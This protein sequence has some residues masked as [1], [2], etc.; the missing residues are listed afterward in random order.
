MIRRMYRAGSARW[1]LPFSYSNALTQPHGSVAFW[2][3][4][5][6]CDLGIKPL[7]W[8]QT[9]AGRLDGLVKPVPGA[10]SIIDLGLGTTG[11]RL[12]G[13]RPLVRDVVTGNRHSVFAHSGHLSRRL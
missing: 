6:T 9:S 3:E 11:M 10:P 8:L 7:G 13:E 1:E 12:C 5:L 2:K 4:P